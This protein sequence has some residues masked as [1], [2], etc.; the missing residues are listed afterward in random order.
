VGYPVLVRPSYVLSGA[1]MRVVRSS[2]GLEKFLE[3][4]SAVSKEHPVVISKFLLGAWEIEMDGVGNKGDVVVHAIHEHIEQAGVHSGDASLVLPCHKLPEALRLKVFEAGSKIVEAL[5][6]TGP[7][8]A[9]FIV[10]PTDGSVKVIECNVRASRSFPFI[11]KILGVDFIQQAVKAMLDLPID[12][13]LKQLDLK[14]LNFV[15]VKVPNFSFTRLAGADPVLGVEMASTGEVAC[16][17]KTKHEA[18][19]KAMIARNFKLPKQNILLM[20][21]EHKDFFV[22]SA[23]LLAATGYKLYATA[24]THAH[25]K[26]HG[27]DTI[28]CTYDKE[29]YTTPVNVFPM[30]K[31]KQFDLVINFPTPMVSAADDAEY[32]KRYHV[33]RSAID[34]SIPLIN[35]PQVAEMLCESLSMVHTF[36]LSGGD[37]LTHPY[38]YDQAS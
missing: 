25:L 13:A 24:G 6:I 8:N 29:D 34:F 23:K 27:V 20:L 35:N 18:F 10:S 2:E 9:Q 7:F 33:R 16:Y 21:G 22:P 26:A 12:P 1:A 5:K 28:E 15:G 36:D 17:G 3:E 38:N 4:A 11:S 30:L 14:K 32:T 37:E 31:T 19:L